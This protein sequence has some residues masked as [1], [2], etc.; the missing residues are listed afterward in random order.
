MYHTHHGPVTH[1]IDGRWAVTKIN[2]DPVNALIQSFTRTKLDNYAAF[3]EMMNIRTNSS[4]NTVFADAEG[5]IAYFHGNFIPRRDARFDYS[6]P[7]DGSVPA[8]DWQGLHTVDETITILNPPNGWIQNANSTPFTAAAE[9]SPK[10]ADYPAYM[11]P[12][13]ENFRGVHA[14]RVLADVDD[15]TLDGLIELAHDPYLPGFEKLIGGLLEAWDQAEEPDA[16]LAEPIEVLKA[17]DLST[18]KDSVAMSLAHFYGM[19]YLAR[20][21]FPADMSEMER[22]T[23]LGTTTP[24]G[25]R[26]EVFADTVAMLADDYGDWRT[27]WGE[28]NRFQRL[29]GDDRSRV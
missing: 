19:N 8:T 16:A 17:W 3:R 20:A 21:T 11:A 27:P 9:F 29:S 22:I 6:Q 7:V 4:N 2:W 25:Q 24:P 23:M 10:R 5:N 18:G 15:L 14:V 26:L 12:D 28:I 1:A 13:D